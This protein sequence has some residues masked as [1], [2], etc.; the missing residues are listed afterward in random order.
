MKQ[1]VKIAFDQIIDAHGQLHAYARRDQRFRCE[2]FHERSKEATSHCNNCLGSTHPISIEWIKARHKQG[3]LPVS[4]P[5]AYRTSD[6]GNWKYEAHVYYVKSEANP[7]VGDY[8]LDVLTHNHQ[9][10]ISRKMLISMVD[11]K[12]LGEDIIFYQVYT[13]EIQK[14]DFDDLAIR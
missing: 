12:M 14:G 4:L 11:P 3:Q 7:V 5:D 9:K 10:S 2:C 8:V 6:A 13:R 1:N